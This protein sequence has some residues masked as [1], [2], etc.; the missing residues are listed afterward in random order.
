MKPVNEKEKYAVEWNESAQFF[1][2][3]NS[4]KHL[5]THI[6]GYKKVLEIGCGTGQSTLALLRAGC[7]VLAI[8]QNPYCIEKAK[9]LVASAGFTII[10]SLDELKPRSVCFLEYDITDPLFLQETLPRV[11][12]DVVTCWNMGTYWDKQKE[13]DVF[14][15]MLEYGLT[16][17][18]IQQNVE[19]SYVE[20]VIWNACRIAKKCKCAV[21]IVDRGTYPL[22]RLNDPYY[23]K[24]KKEFGFGKIKYA[25]IKATTLSS[26][27]R[28][29]ITNG[30]LNEEKAV[31][32]LFISVLM[33]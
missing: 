21:H 20:L 32:I 27:G 11:S 33:K 5:I 14:P 12:A 25:N 16:V 28:L 3:H 18:Q 7:C 30:M 19:S 9:E 29:L 24:L 8:E 17:D 4:Y 15:K 13:E 31:P 2:N 22:N 26:G 1:F 23:V 6:S 10:E